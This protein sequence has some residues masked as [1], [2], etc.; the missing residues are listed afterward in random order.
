MK[1]ADSPIIHCLDGLSYNSHSFSPNHFKLTTQ[2]GVNFE[3]KGNFSILD[4]I[5]PAYDTFFVNKI[6]SININFVGQNL[7]HHI[8]T[9]VLGTKIPFY[10]KTIKIQYE[11][12]NHQSPCL[13]VFDNTNIS[14]V[15]I[16]E[17]QKHK[18]NFHY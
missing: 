2:E 18:F 12:Q 3:L 9:I 15:L 13:V 16:N 14:S 11:F 5:D 4:Y 7:S 6:K 1:L 17:V 8:V 10:T